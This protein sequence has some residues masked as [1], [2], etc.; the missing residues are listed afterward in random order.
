VIV[1]RRAGRVPRSPRSA[2]GE[3][4]TP[5]CRRTARRR[6]AAGLAGS[7]LLLAALAGEGRA[8][9]CGAAWRVDGAPPAS[10]AVACRDGDPACDGDGLADGGCRLAV[11]LCVAADGC[12][13]GAAPRVEARGRAA[14]ELGAAA[15]ALPLP[16]PGAPAC[17]ADVPVR[18]ELGRRGRRA[19]RLVAVTRGAGRA[20]RERLRLLCARRAPAG[21][22]RAVVV[23]T[24]FE[25][26]LLA[27]V[28]VGRPRRVG[29]PSA[30]IHA[31][32]VVRTAGGLVYV[33]NR[34]LGDNLQVLD[35]AR[36]FRTLLQCSTGAGS[37]PHDVAVAGP[38]KAYVTRY[39]ARELWVVDPGARSCGAFRLGTVD[40]APYGDPDGLPEMDQMALVGDRLF[41]SLGRLD[42][43][44]RFAPAGPSRL[45]VLD[46]ATDGVVGVVELSGA[47][48][49]SETSGLAREPWSGKLVVAAAGSLFRTGDGGLERVDPEA[50]RAEGFFITED[51]LGGSV[52]DFVLVSPT[53]GYAVVFVADD[54]PRN[55][56]VAFDPARGVVTRRLLTRTYNLP[57]LALAPDGTLWVADQALPAPGIRIFDPADDRQLTRRAV[58]V[59]LPPFSMTFLP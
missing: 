48:A 13:P 18:L 49:F 55:L 35:P 3:G 47:N 30:P 7:A 58:D 24:D 6:A 19:A 25:T 37:N 27:T 38:R 34:F 11:S 10:R 46:T 26:G 50:L 53:K 57:D 54:P 16:G 28:R 44:R 4:D 43:T 1:R 51:A 42:R 9:T 39:D 40:L 2:G 31:D 22:G 33:V 45:A 59:G 12:P 41:V 23:T 15:A 14:A 36:G 21:G 17:T 56:L 29:R 20:R 5:S 8:A 32:A 52:T